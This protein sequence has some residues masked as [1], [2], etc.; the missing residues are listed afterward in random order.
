MKTHIKI[1]NTLTILVSLFL[2]SC[3]EN[4]EEVTEIPIIQNE[5]N[6]R[7]QEIKQPFGITTNGNYLIFNSRNSYEAVMNNPSRQLQ[8]NL[9]EVI[10]SIDFKKYSPIAKRI[11]DKTIYK[12]TH[13][14]QILNKDHSVQIGSN[15]YRVNLL[16]K[17]VFVLAANFAN[18]YSDLVNE[19]TQNPHI[20]R[21]STLENVLDLVENGELSKGIGCGESKAPEA[22]QNA[23]KN[24][25]SLGAFNIHVDYERAGIYCSASI[26][27]NAGFLLSATKRLYISMENVWYKARCRTAPPVIN[28]PWWSG[29]FHSGYGKYYEV[30]KGTRRLNG[31]HLKARAWFEKGSSSVYK[32]SVTDWV[33]IEDN[34][35]Y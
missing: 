28:D 5:L 19:N 33:S 23:Y 10:H 35:P 29:G 26:Y 25:P 17:S 21:Y 24:Y 7:T 3:S 2:F 31:Y 27:A 34:S 18:E 15:I 6:L 30:Y 32:V 20:K 16:K 14:S 9:K 13:F 8:N 11:E 4:S 1:C 22:H 12:D